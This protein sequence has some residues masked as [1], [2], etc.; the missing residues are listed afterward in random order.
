MDLLSYCYN[1]LKFL[2]VMPIK[3]FNVNENCCVFFFSMIIVITIF[4]NMFLISDRESFTLCNILYLF[5]N[6]HF[7]YLKYF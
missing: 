5:C 6:V 4:L 1:F 7:I 2:D 3:G